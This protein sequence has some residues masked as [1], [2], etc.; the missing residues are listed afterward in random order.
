M[1]IRQPG[2]QE[3][4]DGQARPKRCVLRCFRKGAV[5]S[6][7]RNDKGRLFQRTGAQQLLHPVTVLTL[8]MVSN[9]PWFDRRILLGVAFVNMLLKYE[10]CPDCIVLNVGGI[11]LKFIFDKTKDLQPSLFDYNYL[12]PF[13][14]PLI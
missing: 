8:G 4:Y 12:A 11:T 10:G 3:T 9:G 7:E 13:L 14:Q 5:E 6:S 1:V 2:D